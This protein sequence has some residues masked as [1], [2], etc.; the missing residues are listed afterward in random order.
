MYTP[1]A[2]SADTQFAPIVLVIMHS[3]QTRLLDTARRSV[4]GYFNSRVY[5][6]VRHIRALVDTRTRDR[7]WG[8][9]H[10]DIT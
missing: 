9:G 6:Y 3:M 1:L 5:T 7:A 10:Y 4:R 2:W 8:N